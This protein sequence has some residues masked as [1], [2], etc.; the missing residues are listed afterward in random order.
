M[1]DHLCDLDA[2][3]RVLEVKPLAPAV[4]AYTQDW[5]DL[6]PA[7]DYY[8]LTDE[9]ADHCK[10]SHISAATLRKAGYAIPSRRR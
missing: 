4:F 7:Q 8:E 5:G 10:G 2:A 3:D 1:T 9:I 6:A